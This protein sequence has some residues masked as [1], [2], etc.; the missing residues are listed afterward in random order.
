MQGTSVAALGH[1]RMA[2][3]LKVASMRAGGLDDDDV[4]GRHH[5]Q[6]SV[7]AWSGGQNSISQ[8]W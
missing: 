3:P 6:P 2:L 8:F 1:G 7:V 5:T 4:D